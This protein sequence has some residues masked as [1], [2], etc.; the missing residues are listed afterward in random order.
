MNPIDEDPIIK[1]E[2]ENGIRF[3]FNLWPTNR[4]DA[5]SSSCPFGCLYTPLKKLPPL[6]GQERAPL[7]YEPSFC[8]NCHAALNSYARIDYNSKIWTCPLCNARNSLPTSYNAITPELLP[9][10]LHQAATTI[11]Y[12]KSNS[13]ILP[14]VFLFV[15]DTCNSEKEHAALKS[16]LLQAIAAVPGN[17]YV[18]LITYGKY[19]TIHELA[20]S[21]FPRSYVFSGNKVYTSQDLTRMVQAQ[22]TQTGEMVSKV[23][24][25]IADAESMINSIIDGLDVDKSVPGKGERASRCTGAALHAAVTLLEGLF[26]ITGGQIFIFTSGPITRGPGQMAPL[27]RTEPIRQ[28]SDVEKGKA[29]LSKNSLAFFQEL[30]KNASAKNIVVNYL[31]A[32]FEESGLYEVEPCVLNTG[33]WVL[34]GESWSDV[35]ISQTIVKYFEDV[36]MNAGTE[37]SVKVICSPN[38]KISGCIGP[39]SSMGVA[40]SR[41]SEKVVGIGGTTQWH[42]CGALPSTTLAFYFDIFASKADPVPTGQPAIIQFITTYRHI[43]TGSYRT[44]VTTTGIQFLDMA[45]NRAQIGNSFDQEAATVLLARLAMWKVRDEDLIDVIHYIDR[46]LIRFCRWFGTYNAGDPSSFSL[47]PSFSVFPTFLYHLR[48]SPFMSTF[49]SSLDQTASLR[50][51]LLMEET[52]NSLFMIQPTLFQYTTSETAAPVNLDMSSLTRDV[53]LLLDTFFRVLV[54][55]GGDIA[56]WRDQGLAENEEYSNIK[57]ALEKPLQEAQALLNERF[58]TPLLI[59]CDQDSSLSR[60]L[61]ARCNP[62]NEGY[63]GLGNAG[64]DSLGSDDEPS[65]AKFMQKLREV[66]VND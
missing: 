55:Y 9:L 48:R 17:A 23:I 12:M 7:G 52:S 3:S 44:R 20:Y 33:G 40:D 64:Q 2:D 26:P 5:V 39:C 37:V 65:L 21:D 25:P 59:T 24:L 45:N 63:N 49:N 53:V 31:A 62:S 16:V 29:E 61:L 30:G 28:H 58:P 46:T 13:S 4:I 14:P 38:F 54:W 6:E 34:S 51:S 60:F 15:V 19:I 57:W 50:H 43:A 47:G 56:A 27:P 22:R 32:C 41:V 8:N 42:L 1:R 18:G 10:E 36:L 35:N 66:A 11:E